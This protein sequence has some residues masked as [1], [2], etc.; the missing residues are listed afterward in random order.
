MN[1]KQVRRGGV[2]PHRLMGQ[3]AVLPVHS[4]RTHVPKHIDVILGGHVASIQSDLD[5]SEI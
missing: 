3:R 1:R 5:H 2:S 4:G